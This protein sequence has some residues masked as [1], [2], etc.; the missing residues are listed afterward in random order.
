M[1]SSSLVLL[2]IAQIF[3]VLLCAPLIKGVIERGKHVVQSKRGPSVFQPYYDYWKLLQKGSV[4]SEH[5]SW[6]FRVAPYLAFVTPL[7]VCTLIPV[8][9][10]YP[11]PYAFMGDMLAGGFIL[12]LGGFFTSLAALDTGSTYGGMGSSRARVVSFLA[13][14]AVILVLFTVA[15]VAQSTIPFDV[16]QALVGPGYL[17]NPAHWL[18]AAALFMVILA[19]GGRLP[20]DNPSSHF[21]LSMIEHA[22]SLEYSGPAL[23]LIEWGGAMKVFVLLV[24]LLNVLTAPWGLAPAGA[25]TILSVVVAVATLLLKM[26][27]ICGIV[28]VIESCVAK[29]RFFRI[30]EYL[31][32]AFIVAGLAVVS[33]YLTRGGV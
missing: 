13:E 25:T 21:E 9:T 5:A 18:L 3:T 10:A 28:I 7:A 27:V 30:P 16:N 29:W 11:L 1:P 17:F 15:L 19:E 12:A 23:A 33:F 32:A 24:I 31:G 4:I 6:I 22:R 20:V 2:Q 8:L 26:F 14:P